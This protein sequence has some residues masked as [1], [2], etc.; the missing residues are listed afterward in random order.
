MNLLQLE[1]WDPE[2]GA[3]NVILETAKGNRNKRAGKRFREQRQ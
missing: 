2:T 1:T 3:L